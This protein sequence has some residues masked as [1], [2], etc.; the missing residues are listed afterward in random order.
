MG[1]EAGDGMFTLTL[2]DGT[3]ETAKRVL[4]ASGMDYRHLD[5]P[6]VTERWGRSVFHCP[7]CHGWEVH[8]QALGVL[9]PSPTDGCPAP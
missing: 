3:V 4:L 2:G 5:R 1:G 7:F 9:D 8:D 6:G